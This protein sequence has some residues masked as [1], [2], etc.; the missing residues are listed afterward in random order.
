M[1]FL[2]GE[3]QGCVGLSRISESLRSEII[4]NCFNCLVDFPPRFQN[5]WELLFLL[6]ITDLVE[7]TG[8][9]IPGSG[10]AGVWGKYGVPGSVKSTGCGINKL[11][12]NN[13]SITTLKHFNVNS[14]GTFELKYNKYVGSCG[15]KLQYIGRTVD[16]KIPK[17]Y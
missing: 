5:F 4:A 3:T 6:I 10:P 12:K 7:K 8:R 16:E 1:T 13:V 14:T 11:N 2:I 9:G 17:S 15:G